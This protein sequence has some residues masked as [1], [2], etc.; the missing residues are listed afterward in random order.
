MR[1]NTWLG[2]VDALAQR[3]VEDGAPIERHR[4]QRRTARGVARLREQ[5]TDSAHGRH[6]R[7]LRT[8]VD[9][10]A[11][12]RTAHAR[13]AVAR[14]AHAR[15]AVARGAAARGGLVDGA[16]RS[17]LAG[18]M[19]QPPRL[20]LQHA[21]RPPL[22]VRCE[23]TRRRLPRLRRLRRARLPQKRRRERVHVGQGPGAAFAERV[24]CSEGA[25]RVPDAAA[26]VQVGSRRR[27][28]R[29]RRRCH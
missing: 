20:A 10:V 26:A 12:G 19:Q 15:T 14:T 2:E 28:Q 23:H 6:R 11:R 25:R 1:R 18:G 17:G 8:V 9:G 13:T 22:R 24:G 21:R 7:R 4:R 27:L 3:R 29:E 16:R 5:E